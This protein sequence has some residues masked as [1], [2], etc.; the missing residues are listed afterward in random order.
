MAQIGGR[1]SSTGPVIA[2]MKLISEKAV[3]PIVI[4]SPQLFS[5]A[6]GGFTLIELLVVIAISLMVMSSP[7][8]GP[9]AA[10]NPRRERLSRMQ[11]IAPISN[12]S[13]IACPD[14]EGVGH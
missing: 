12:G 1:D 11:P 6:S 14:R 5:R 4:H 2:P 8:N 3:H 10:P 13:K 7:R 9:G